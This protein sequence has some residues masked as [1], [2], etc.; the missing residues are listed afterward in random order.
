MAE[1]VQKD[2]RARKRA[3]PAQVSVRF[4]RPRRWGRD[5]Q[6]STLIPSGPAARGVMRLHWA[7][8][9]PSTSRNTLPPPSGKRRGQAVSS[10]GPGPAGYPPTPPPTRLNSPDA[11]G[12]HITASRRLARLSASHRRGTESIRFAAFAT[13][14]WSTAWRASGPTGRTGSRVPQVPANGSLRLSNRGQIRRA[15]RRGPGPRRE[16][17]LPGG[18]DG[19]EACPPIDH[20]R[21]FA[22]RRGPERGRRL[23]CRADSSRNRLVV[24]PLEAGEA[25]P[26]GITANPCKQCIYE[27]LRIRSIAH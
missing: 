20:G 4:A 10:S 19:R 17:R 6:G 27:N 8:H 26:E 5:P 22:P 7:R 24:R 23:R 9:P 12:P 11:G 18:S 16:P 25:G 3:G 2:G 21:G 1:R 13:S 15:S 14:R